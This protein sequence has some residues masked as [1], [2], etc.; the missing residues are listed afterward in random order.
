MNMFMQGQREAGRGL[1][2]CWDSLYVPSITLAGKKGRRVRLRAVSGSMGRRKSWNLK[3][4]AKKTAQ[5]CQMVLSIHYIVHLSTLFP[6]RNGTFHSVFLLRLSVWIL[7]KWS[8]F[9]SVLIRTLQVRQC[10]QCIGG[11]WANTPS[12]KTYWF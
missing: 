8:L 2:D 5:K 12:V 10:R 9:L 6:I 11:Q 3:Q 7:W 4:V 1:H